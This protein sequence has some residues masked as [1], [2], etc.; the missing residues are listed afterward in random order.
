MTVIL[1]TKEGK[2]TTEEEKLLLR[3]AAT[4]QEV[5]HQFTGEKPLKNES[6][7]TS[8]FPESF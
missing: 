7:C 2:W 6:S 8:I 3:I 1:P 4:T 5:Y